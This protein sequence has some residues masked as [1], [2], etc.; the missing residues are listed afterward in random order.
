MYRIAIA[1]SIDFYNEEVFNQKVDA[2][3]RNMTGHMEIVSGDDPGTEEMALWYAEAKKLRYKSI[4]T[5]W[6]DIEGKPTSEIGIREFGE[7]FWINAGTVR[8]QQVVDYCSHLIAF[9]AKDDETTRALI[10]LATRHELKVRTIMIDE[11]IE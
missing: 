6:D 3:L 11:Y 1:G 8:N 5:L 7:R 4:P 9:L 10:T 2:V